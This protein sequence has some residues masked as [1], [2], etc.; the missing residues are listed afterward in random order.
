MGCV[1][2]NLDRVVL[3]LA[4][5]C[6]GAVAGAQ[7]TTLRSLST[8]NEAR[9][10][11]AVG[12]LDSANGGYC[13]GTLISPDVV[14]TAAHCVFDA[15]TAEMVK[16]GAMRFRAGLTRGKVAAE[17]TVVQVIPHE[18]FDPSAGFNGDNVI[19]DVALVRLEKPIPVQDVAPF[20]VHRGPI[21]DGPVSVVSYGKGRDDMLT[22]QNRCKVLQRHKRLIAMDCDVTY[23]SSGAPVFTHLNGRGRILS[24]ISGI[25]HHYGEK[26]SFG[27]EL[28]EAIEGLKVRLRSSAPRPKAKVRRLGLGDGKV[29]TGAKFVRP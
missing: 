27:M 2:R 8:Q 10:F 20:V 3:A 25:G 18:R 24:V 5:G 9:A 16:P 11:A 14:L 1:A 15:E 6:L 22:R 26:V 7:E 28:P 29:T 12:R 13:T 17:R 4:L 21:G 23:G 19:Y